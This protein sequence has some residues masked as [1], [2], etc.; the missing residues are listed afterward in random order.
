MFKKNIKRIICVGL[1]ALAAFAWTGRVVLNA[2][3]ED[4]PMIRVMLKY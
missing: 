2:V 4:T 3:E 1:I